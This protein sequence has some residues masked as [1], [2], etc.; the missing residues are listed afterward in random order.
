MRYD[1]GTVPMS[2]TAFMNLC[3]EMNKFSYKYFRDLEHSFGLFMIVITAFY[4][5]VKDGIDPYS[6]NPTEARYWMA[7]AQSV[8]YKLS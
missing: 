7:L 8:L 4:P 6:I 5:S 2:L 3:D 1:L